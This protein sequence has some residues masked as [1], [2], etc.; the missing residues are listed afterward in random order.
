MNPLL[1]KV[2][3]IG[4]AQVKEYCF[5]HMI[6]RSVIAVGHDPDE[7]YVRLPQKPRFLQK[8][9]WEDMYPS[10]KPRGV[11]IAGNLN[12]RRGDETK[13]GAIMDEI[14]GFACADSFRPLRK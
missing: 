11:H 14:D 12:L 6:N 7:Q 8:W 4:N 13:L 1:E 3:A 9:S 10:S 2:L 5:F